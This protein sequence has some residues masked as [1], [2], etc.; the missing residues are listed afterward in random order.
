MIDTITAWVLSALG[1]LCTAPAAHR[2]RRRHRP[3]RRPPPSIPSPQWPG[4]HRHGA[5]RWRRPAW[6]GAVHGQRVWGGR[7]VR[8]APG[9]VA[10]ADSCLGVGAELADRCLDRLVRRHIVE[11]SAGLRE[12]TNLFYANESVRIA[13]LGVGIPRSDDFA[14][15]DAICCKGGPQLAH[16]RSSGP[17]FLGLLFG[18]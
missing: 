11:R 14:A 18:A 2:S 17:P 16:Q 9:G 12:N 5:G 3:G 6:H 8:A 15:K 10:L 7:A 1:Y 13:G 4:N